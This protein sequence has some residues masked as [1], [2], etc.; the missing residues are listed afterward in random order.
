MIRQIKRKQCVI[1]ELC[2]A[3]KRKIRASSGRIVSSS[4]GGHDELVWIGHNCGCN[5]NNNRGDDMGVAVDMIEDWIWV[6]IILMI[7]SLIVAVWSWKH[8]S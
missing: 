8:E 3:L 6:I 1:R 7:L 2:F 5:Y 4:R